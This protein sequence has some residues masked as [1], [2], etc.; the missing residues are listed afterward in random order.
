MAH[1]FS[2]FFKIAFPLSEENVV[3]V[4]DLEIS[5]KTLKNHSR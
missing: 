5:E 2:L 1:N 3:T 4:D